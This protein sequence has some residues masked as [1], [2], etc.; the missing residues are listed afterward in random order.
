M[1]SNDLDFTSPHPS[2]IIS[3]IE[4]I[5]SY[6]GDFPLAIASGVNKE[7][8]KLFEPLVDYMLVA[9]SITDHNEMIDEI[10]LQ[11]LLNS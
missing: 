8:K 3:K 7:N 4:K 2:D 6:I 1:N 9:S 10:K 5:R 11:E